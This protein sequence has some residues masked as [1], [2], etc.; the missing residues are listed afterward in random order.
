MSPA[1][2]G[3]A[4]AAPTAQQQ[5]ATTFATRVRCRKQEVGGKSSQGEPIC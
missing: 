5:R 2:A 1:A 3:A 4:P